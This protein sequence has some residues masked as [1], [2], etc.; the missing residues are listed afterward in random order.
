KCFLN[1]ILIELRSGTWKSNLLSEIAEI[2]ESSFDLT[3]TL[4]GMQIDLLYHE[5]DRPAYVCTVEELRKR[6]TSA[7]RELF[8]HIELPMTLS[9]SVDHFGLAL[10]SLY[11]F[12]VVDEDR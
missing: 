10:G 1:A 11:P 6:T 7:F 4:I 8:R 12:V 3:S 5:S 9:D 2:G